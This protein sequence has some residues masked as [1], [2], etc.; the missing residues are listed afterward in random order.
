MYLGK[1]IS[2][3]IPCY[4]EEE[5]IV[6]TIKKVP[7]V[8]DEIIVVDNNSTDR[9]SKL[10]KSAGARVILETNKGYG[11]ALRR[12]I[13]EAT[14][15]IVVTADGDA[16]YPIEDIEK[17]VDFLIKNNL[18]F[19][20]CNRLP[21]DTH[22]S[23]GIT[24][25]IG[26]K[27]LNGSAWLLFGAK[28]RDILSG[29]WAFYK[30]AYEKLTLVSYDWNLSEEIKIEALKKCRFSEFHIN[31]HSRIGQTKLLKWRVGLENLIFL[32]WKKLFENKKLPPQLKLT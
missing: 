31:H 6:P 12:G 28:F 14:G 23:M 1:K 18:E 4:N 3:V 9:T 26:T 25:I 11:Y 21:L 7:S 19:V 15:E 16:T 10:A 13:K 20:S 22:K 29:M 24:N 5:S 27:V 8:V 2:I 32:F 17:I 30:S